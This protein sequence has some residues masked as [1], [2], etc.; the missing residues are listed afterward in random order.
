M[1]GMRKEND[2]EIGHTSGDVGDSRKP[3]HRKARLLKLSTRQ[4]VL[5]NK[6]TAIIWVLLILPSYLWWKDA[7]F[8]VIVCSIYANVKADWSTAEA[9]DD[10][11]LKKL[12]NDIKD[13]NEL[14]IS[15]LSVVLENKNSKDSNERPAH[16]SYDDIPA[17]ESDELPVMPVRKES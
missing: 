11:E 3:S 17:D 14:I 6:T 7:V 12:L 16:D 9:A 10:R 2:Q 4:K 13:Q 5:F 15:S 8:F 1:S